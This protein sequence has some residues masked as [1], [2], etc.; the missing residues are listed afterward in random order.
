M[1]CISIPV[2]FLYH[3]T[4]R[5][6]LSQMKVL[7]KKYNQEKEFWFNVVPLDIFNPDLMRPQDEITIDVRPGK[8]Q[9]GRASCRE[10]V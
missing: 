6:L 5:P 7:V 9:I 8:S 1:H 3:D 2:A 10:R 4:S